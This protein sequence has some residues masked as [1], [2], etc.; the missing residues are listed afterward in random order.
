[1]VYI[2]FQT[3]AFPRSSILTGLY[4]HNTQVT[5]NSVSGNCY[6]S[7]WRDHVEKT[8]FGAL[9]QSEG[10]YNTFYAGKYLNR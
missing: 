3:F 9:L 1:M 5:N 10:E 6:G 4:Q 2:F 8:N 7:Y